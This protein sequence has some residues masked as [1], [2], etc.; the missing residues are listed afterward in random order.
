MPSIRDRISRFRSPARLAARA[1]QS[2]SRQAAMPHLETLEPRII[3]SATGDVFDVSQYI[4][5]NDADGIQD[6]AVGDVNGDGIDDIAAIDADENVFLAASFR[7][8]FRMP[9]ELDAPGVLGSS[10]GNNIEMADL[11]NDGHLDIVVIDNGG[12]RAI[13]VFIND[14]NGNFAAPTQV[15]AFG[16]NARDWAITDIT[17]DNIPDIVLLFENTVEGYRSNGDGTATTL[18]FSQ[19]ESATDF[20]LVDVGDLDGDNLPDIAVYDDGGDLRIAKGQ[21]GGN[22]SSFTTFS[23]FFDSGM[24]SLVLADL[25]ADGQVDQIAGID[26][27]GDLLSYTNTSTLST[28][29][30]AANTSV[31]N[32]RTGQG[33]L[34]VGDVNGDGTADLVAHGSSAFSIYFGN[35]AAGARVFTTASNYIVQESVDLTRLGDINNDGLLDVFGLTNNS[36]HIAPNLG[37]ASFAVPEVAIAGG[38]V[39]FERPDQILIGDLNGD[40]T[41]DA[42]LFDTNTIA[43]GNTDGN[44]RINFGTLGRFSADN[45]D[46]ATA[47]DSGTDQHLGG[48]LADTDG[49]GDLDIILIST[50]GTRT[51]SQV[52]RNDGGATFTAIDPRI[53]TGGVINVADVWGGAANGGAKQDVIVADATGNRLIFL[54]GQGTGNVILVDRLRI[55]TEPRAIEVAD[56][57][58]DGDL[59]IVIATDLGVS[60]LAATG[61]FVYGPRVDTT[62]AAGA[63]DIAVGNYNADNAPDVTAITGTGYGEFVF[64]RNRT[65]TPDQLFLRHLPQSDFELTFNAQLD[66]IVQGD[67][68]A[69]GT[70][71]FALFGENTRRYITIAGDGFLGAAEVAFYQT[72]SGSGALSPALVDLDHDGDLDIAYLSTAGVLDR[73]GIVINRNY[74]DGSFVLPDLGSSSI[75]TFLAPLPH[76]GGQRATLATGDF[77]ND[78]LADIAVFEGVVEGPAIVTYLNTG[79]GFRRAT[80]TPVTT[81]DFEI[82]ST[83]LAVGDVTGDGIDDIVI[84]NDDERRHYTFINDGAGTSYTVILAHSQANFTYTALDLADMTGD[85]VLDIVATDIDNDVVVIMPGRNDGTFRNGAVRIVINVPDIASGDRPHIF[86]GDGDGLLDFAIIRGDVDDIRFHRQRDARI[87]EFS[88]I[89]TAPSSGSIGQILSSADLNGD[90]RAELLVGQ[91]SSANGVFSIL[92]NTSTPGTPVFTQA[93]FD[94]PGRMEADDGVLAAD[95]DNDGRTELLIL[96][97]AL[98]IVELNAAGTPVSFVSLS[99]EIDDRF[100]AL[101]QDLDNDGDLDFLGTSR[102]FLDSAGSLIHPNRIAGTSRLSNV[103]PFVP[104]NTITLD[105]QNFGMPVD[106]T[107]DSLLAKAGV[108][109]A[110]GDTDFT[111]RIIEQLAGTLTGPGGVL[112]GN[113]PLVDGITLTYELPSDASSTTAAFRVLVSDQ[114]AEGASVITVLVPLVPQPCS[115]GPIAETPPPPLAQPD[116]RWLDFDP[117]ELAD[118]KADTEADASNVFWLTGV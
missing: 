67:L 44:V 77:N 50:D 9:V 62:F 87:Y 21:S 59:D 69:D 112:V 102:D 108:V 53:V 76:Q 19:T 56:M 36:I 84:Y 7:A 16:D 79:N 72:N 90:G 106:I 78:G 66:T 2:I 75:S 42:V 24:T 51:L 33:N 107:L 25:D 31:A 118:A 35:T 45:L 11:T 105:A 8:A 64:L 115:T 117:L 83:Q 54:A 29:S 17:G 74:G 80:V 113:R 15:L 110:D 1:G 30:F 12:D 37:N 18:L 43:S 82:S 103:T 99:T 85:G 40:G 92:F 49:D 114:F 109:D 14:G 55:G 61:N 91:G 13:N 10:S 22:A 28:I 39:S 63:R 111:F 93:D 20:T 3:L 27:V 98:T 116:Q 65:A 104:Q 70:P 4:R 41:Q 96:G 5:F 34:A 88:T 68:D 57:D 26:G 58:G 38:A 52:L 81:T 60:A 32:T 73:N 23:S 101:L 71:D 47:V 89:W 6:F 100:S 95:I 97:S 46:L 48:T 94:V 86:D